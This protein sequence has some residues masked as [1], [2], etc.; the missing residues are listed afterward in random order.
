MS[1]EKA[2]VNWDP[3]EKTV[4]ANEQVDADGRSWR[5]GALVEQRDLEQWFLRITH[6]KEALLRDLDKLG[7]D[8]AW[9]ERVLAMQKNWIGRSE[10]AYY[11]FPATALDDRFTS[12][13]FEVFTTRPETI[14]AAQYIAISPNSSLAQSLAKEYGFEHDLERAKTLPH[15]SR[16]GFLVPNVR[17]R[18]P[19]ALAGLNTA[20]TAAQADFL[21]VYIAPYV[22]GDYETAAL[23]GVPAHDARDFAF[24]KRH[25]PDDP[26]LYALTTDKDGSLPKD[27][28]APIVV[29]GYMTSIAGQY[30]GM[31][32][33]E[34]ASQVVR[35]IAQ[36]TRSNLAPQRAGGSRLAHGPLLARSTVKWKLRDWL[37]SRQRYWG[38]PIPIIHCDE[39]G[40][41]PVPED[42]LPVTLPKV[43]HHWAG[44]RTGNPL[45]T[46]T[47]WIK[48]T[49]PKCHGPARR[50]TDTMDTFMDSSWYYM[51]F[52]DPHNPT[53]PIS[54]EAAKKHLPVD[55][56]IGGVEHAILHL[57]YSR[58][59]YK[60]VMG[61]LHSGKTKDTIAGTEPTKG[62]K[63]MK[64][65]TT[66]DLEPFKRLI[67]QGMVHG[68]T[69][70]DPATGRFLKPDEVDLTDP[71]APTIAATGQR[72]TVSYEKMSKSKHNGVD[73]G[74][75]IARY[76]ADPT[77]A[78]I[79]FQAPVGD[80]LNWDEH[81]IAGVTRWLM[82]VHDLVLALGPRPVPVD[83]DF[84]AAAHFQKTAEQAD[85]AAR[86]V[87]AADAELWRATQ[88]TIVS[89]TRSMER[90]YSLNTAVS[91]LMNLTNALARAGTAGAS[92]SLRAA[93]AAHLLRMLAPIAPAVAEECWAALHSPG[94]E[95][96]VSTLFG[97]D[98]GRRRAQWPFP[99]GTLA[100][101]PRADTTQCAVMVNGKRRCVVEVPAVAGEDGRPGDD[102][103]GVALA[104]WLTAQILRTLEAGEGGGK[105]TSVDIRRAR[106]A[107]PVRGGK[108]INYV[109][110]D[111]S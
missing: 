44:G 50:D 9:P 77:R 41:Q 102:A 68:K 2:T 107:I 42:Q 91:D 90:V 15:D 13:S 101:L 36:E 32:S 78:H 81:K 72:P 38:T 69:Y 55:I 37:I 25:C 33:E 45:E 80:V 84:D 94:E 109:V 8:D 22:R 29:P 23:M 95:E 82:R 103:D 27:E 11:R 18:N 79:L 100:S 20:A 61:L 76:G 67:T 64:A 1:R 28:G 34:A 58:F 99:D 110:D 30:E 5:S 74:E 17:A 92:P 96:Q 35:R 85:E 65:A 104:A 93:S 52:P 98:G 60:A 31:P 62:D 71:Q 12:L 43:S 88:N 54:E 106:R 40:I 19:V 26:I 87:R 39:C 7:A 14:F 105:R 70:T 66:S 47:D 10:G 111:K 63:S 86:R 48:T 3:V 21:P 97:H 16:E 46:A 57:L 49:C 89:V 56:Y 24:W 53:L 6:F 108:V 83:D 73:P 51:R 59:V 75:F 4:L